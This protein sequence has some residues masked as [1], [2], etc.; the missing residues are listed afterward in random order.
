MVQIL[1]LFFFFF[2]FRG[3]ACPQPN[4]NARGEP[5]V[6]Q[7]Q[8]GSQLTHNQAKKTNSV[9]LRDL[10]FLWP[11]RNLSTEAL[12]GTMLPLLSFVLSFCFFFPN[13]CKI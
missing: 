6:S 11:G 10:D 7:K 1:L 4:E 9:D 3:I 5:E 2:F 13:I 8:L 12:R